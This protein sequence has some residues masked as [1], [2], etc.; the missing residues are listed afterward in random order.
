[1]TVQIAID[2]QDASVLAQ[3]FVQRLQQNG[4]QAVWTSGQTA[5]LP[6]SQLAMICWERGG[7]DGIG[8]AIR[9][10][11]AVAWEF[12]WQSARAAARWKGG[13]QHAEIALEEVLKWRSDESA[14]TASH[15]DMPPWTFVR[16]DAR[17]RDLFIDRVLGRR[18]VPSTGNSPPH[19]VF[20]GSFC[21]L[22]QGHR[23]MVNVAEGRIGQP[24]EL[25]ISIHNVDKPTLDFFE[26]E[27]RLTSI[28]GYR[29]IW[30][31]RAPTFIQK[32]A[33]F[34][35]TTFLIG[36][37]TIRRIIDLSY[38]ADA[39]QQRQVQ[40]ELVERGC[41]FLVFGRV[42]QGKFRTISPLELP[43]ELRGIC[44]MVPEAEFREDISST[45]VRGRT[46]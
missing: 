3:Q 20:P 35:D 4:R 12:G 28:A 10:L 15:V 46:S 36:D 19:L 11:S 1:M 31:T 8:L 37:D 45:N 41:R 42:C 6:I 23:K 33:L 22:H 18:L 24:V 25:E 17:W 9:R 30:L 26:I 5:E 14:F 16:A 7:V 21:P 34:P 27:Q 13:A 44:Q 29:P 38:Y 2:G 40:R 43:T 39:R 32:T